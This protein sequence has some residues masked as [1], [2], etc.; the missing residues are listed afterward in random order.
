MPPVDPMTSGFHRPSLNTGI[1]PSFYPKID[2]QFINNNS[3]MMGRIYG[4][5]GNPT[6]NNPWIEQQHPQS[7]NIM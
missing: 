7:Q 2:S 6:M 5:M 4:S 1:P 3:N